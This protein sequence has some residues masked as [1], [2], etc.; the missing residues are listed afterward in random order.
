[1]S[2]HPVAVITGGAGGI[3]AEI[4][5]TLATAGFRVAVGYHRSAEGA[6]T[7]VTQL[8][9]S[10]HQALALPV[11]DSQALQ[12]A[13]K[14][15]ETEW[16]RCDVLVN[17]AGTT[18]FVAHGDLD[19]LDDALIDEILSVNIRGPFATARAFRALLT[20]SCLE[21]GGVIVNISST[22]AQL[23]IGSNVMYCA[24]KAALDNMTRS[25]SRALAPKIRVVSVS[26]GLVDT[27]FVKSMDPAWRT[28]Q[29]NRT[30]LL[31]LSEPA[32]I[33]RAV[34]CTITQLTFTTGSVILVDG[35][36]ML[37]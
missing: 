32:E 12:A 29:A 1:M 5:R 9:G 17:C 20:R 25:L 33:G 11:T 26:P 4:C 37:G 10:G 36:R 30:P 35:G 24:S 2:S 23:A 19:G 13:A 16:G 8:E 3:G 18:R 21:G 34:L 31:R 7:L 14:Q 15:I 6:S 22:A 27:E 28:E